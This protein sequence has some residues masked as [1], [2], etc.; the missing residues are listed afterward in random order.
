[1]SDRDQSKWNL[2][3]SESNERPLRPASDFLQRYIHQAPAGRALDLA[4]GTGRN[5]LYMARQGFVVDAVDISDVGLAR[6]QRAADEARLAISWHCQDLLASPQIPHPPYQ[7]IVL[8]RF[9]APQLVKRLPNYLAPGGMLLI[10]EHLHKPAD[11]GEVT[12]SGPGS[13]RF[14]VAPG[15]LAASLVGLELAFCD[16]GIVS[17]PDGSVAALARVQA[18][19]PR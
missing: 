3:Y 11:A 9:V 1:M 14:R 10:E 16:E 17:E 5:A 13:R 4:C 7:L 2:R 15:E 12:V 6:A 8:F 18:F 19:K